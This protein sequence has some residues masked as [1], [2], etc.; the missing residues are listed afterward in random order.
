MFAD[1]VIWTSLC[2][3]WIKPLWDLLSL[4]KLHLETLFWYA[5]LTSHILCSEMELF[6]PLYVRSGSRH[7][8]TSSTVTHHQEVHEFYS[9]AWRTLMLLCFCAG[10]PSARRLSADFI[11]D[12]QTLKK[13]LNHA[14]ITRLALGYSEVCGGLPAGLGRLP[15]PSR[16]SELH[17]SGTI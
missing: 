9:A 8:G 5:S 10:R 16:K 7:F 2:Q 13:L 14:Y 11:D 15:L 4:M 3:I 12:G 17:T 1:R 6:G